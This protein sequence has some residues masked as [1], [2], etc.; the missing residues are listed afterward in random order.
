MLER[1]AGQLTVACGNTI[2][3]YTSWTK[4]YSSAA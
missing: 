2:P 4:S 3:P 1:P